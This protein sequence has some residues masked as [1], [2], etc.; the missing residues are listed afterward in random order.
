[1]NKQWVLEPAV[2]GHEMLNVVASPSPSIL[3][4]KVRKWIEFMIFLTLASPVTKLYPDL[5]L[6]WLVLSSQIMLTS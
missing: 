2:T 6:L 4:Y 1:M 5:L 3:I